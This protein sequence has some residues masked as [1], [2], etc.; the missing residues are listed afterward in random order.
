MPERPPAGERGTGQRRP[1]N[2]LR[3]A[4]H[5]YSGLFW[6][7]PR[8]PSL[9]VGIALMLAL[10]ALGYVFGFSP[11]EIALVVLS[12]TILL[13]TET[14]NTAIELFCD[15]MVPESDP[16]IGKVKDVAAAATAFC[17]IGGGVVLLVIVVPR[18]LTWLGH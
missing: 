8:T 5:A 2:I 17:E 14:I 7:A 15:R 11:V 12:G 6:I 16:L 1:W 10:V 18:I 9:K 13:A 4:Y 3:S